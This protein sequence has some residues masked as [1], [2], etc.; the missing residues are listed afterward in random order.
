MTIATKSAFGATLLFCY[1][2]ACGGTTRDFSTTDAD[3]GAAGHSGLQGGGQA[4]QANGGRTDG[5]SG[6]GGDEA[7][8][9]TP[10]VE[11]TCDEECVDQACVA[12]EC[13]GTCAPGSRRCATSGSEETCTPSGT[14]D[15]AKACAYP[16]PSCETDVGCSGVLSCRGLEGTCGTKSEDCCASLLVPGG[17][18]YRSY[19]AV[20]NTEMA[21]I[22][23][24]GDFRLDKFEVT[25]GRFRKFVGAWL[26]G[27]RPA[28][29]VGLH[30]H[31]DDGDG[32]VAGAGGRETGWKP[33]WN[34]K[35][36][37]TATGW[38]ANLSS[39]SPEAA[40]AW[41]ETVGAQ[42]NWPV[43]MVNWYEAYGFCIWDGGF[44][45]TEAEWN[46][47]AAGGNQQRLFPWA[48][49]STAAADSQAVF[50]GK[51]CAL[52]DVG[53]KPGGDAR[54][55]HSDLAGNVVEWALDQGDDPAFSYP[56]PCNNCVG[57]SEGLY[58]A[59]R[60]GDA[61]TGSD[62]LFTGFRLQRLADARSSV[63]AATG[64]VNHYGFRCAREP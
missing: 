62:N 26:D 6:M 12:G 55:G 18:F 16:T 59:Q 24:V 52:L 1:V 10:N 37:A 47:A 61:A 43:D 45:P 39:T 32:L 51:T 48:A 36:A 54:W 49:G 53:S 13:V 50:C 5:S 17:T 38:N 11:A 41:T 2:A 14:W 9:G 56:N 29:G 27:W 63:D 35:L 31:L 7:A 8:G 34:G 33:A 40:P 25:V 23:T 22:S 15:T 20:F 42:E 46:Y 64:K 4:G 19:D 44:L 21:Y 30:T 58:R 60:G 28:A 3:A 57:A